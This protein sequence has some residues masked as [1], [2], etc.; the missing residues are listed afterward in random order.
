MKEPLPEIWHHQLALSL[1]VRP[2]P[3]RELFLSVA[4]ITV[5]PLLE[6]HADILRFTRR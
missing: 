6:F 2:T 3:A 4:A 5:D 1:L